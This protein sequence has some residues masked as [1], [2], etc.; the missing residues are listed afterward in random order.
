MIDN[1]TADG[2]SVVSNTLSLWNIIDRR[3]IGNDHGEGRLV[4][5]IDVAYRRVVARPPC[6]RAFGPSGTVENDA[7]RMTD[8]ARID[9]DGAVDG[10]NVSEELRGQSGREHTGAL[11]L[12]A[13]RFLFGVL[14]G[15]QRTSVARDHG[16][17]K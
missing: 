4:A 6:W 17:P 7:Y 13:L 15:D 9:E 3:V 16:Y 12:H 8:S 5:G 14:G 2:W 11:S 1:L 10:T